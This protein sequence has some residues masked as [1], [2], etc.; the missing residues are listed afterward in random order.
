MIPSQVKDSRRD[1]R[2]KEAALQSLLSIIAGFHAASYKEGQ[3]DEGLREAFKTQNRKW[4]SVCRRKNLVGCDK[5]FA[6]EIKKSW[7]KREQK[8][9]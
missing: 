8:S 6:L 9:Q 2:I 1:R 4:I 7:D 3:T 5:L